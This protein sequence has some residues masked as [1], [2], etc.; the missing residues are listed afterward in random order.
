[1]AFLFVFF[2]GAERY[3]RLTQAGINSRCGRVCPTE[4]APSDRFCLLERRHDLADIGEVA[5]GVIIRK[6]VEKGRAAPVPGGYGGELKITCIFGTRSMPD[7]IFSK[8]LAF[9]HPPGS[10]RPR[11]Y[12][13]WSQYLPLTP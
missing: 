13:S 9:W 12:R 3:S 10:P 1:M 11:R 8:V 7:D 6:L 5:A 2:A 4:H